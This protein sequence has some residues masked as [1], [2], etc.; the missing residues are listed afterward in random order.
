[1][2]SAVLLWRLPD[3][4]PFDQNTPQVLSA[5]RFEPEDLPPNP[6]ETAL[7]PTADDVTQREKLRKK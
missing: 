5:P 6:L 1:M 3:T 4:S 7:P 2:G